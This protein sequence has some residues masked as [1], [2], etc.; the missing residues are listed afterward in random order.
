MPCYLL[1]VTSRYPSRNDKLHMTIERTRTALALDDALQGVMSSR[2]WM[3]L[4]WQEIKQKYRRSL[5]GP[6]WLTMSMAIMVGAMGPLYGKL[7][8]Q[9]IA[10]YLPYLAVSVIAWNLLSQTIIDSCQAFINAESYIKQVRLPLMV[11]V[12][13]VIWKNI[14]IFAH[15]LVVL[16]LVFLF[17]PP[18]LSVRMLLLPVGLLLIC[19]N[20]VWVGMLVGLISARFRDVPQIVASLVQVAFFVTPV[21]WRP[22]Q[23][24]RH[25]WIV[26]FNPFYHFMELVRAPLLGTPIKPLSWLFAVSAALIGFA[27]MIAVVARFRS[28]VAYWV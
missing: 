16:V 28:R 22:Q 20:A 11:Y 12:L 13:R 26:N 5:L 4:G 10:T 14:I 7:F 3:M 2:I 27:V 8:H 19:A 21:M 9:D 15:N 17:L 24:G 18:P 25:A 6:F 1:G 23:L